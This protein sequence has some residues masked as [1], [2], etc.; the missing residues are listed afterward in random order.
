[1]NAELV[2]E[3]RLHV[4]RT[5]M[6]ALPVPSA[7]ES[8]AVLGVSEEQAIEAYRQLADGHVYVLEPGDNIRLRMVNPFSA[9]PT[10]FEVE[11][12]GKS[13]YGNCVWDAVGIISLLG[14]SG[15]VKTICPDCGET[16]LLVVS[17]HQL[18]RKEGVVHFSVP[19]AHWW[20]D[21]IYT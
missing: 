18:V 8:A 17:Q 15:H 21:I 16:M 19:A 4:L 7:P 12:G 10:A 11:A 6:E 1:M 2:N 5:A 9:V 13:Y 3:V 14:G 20:D